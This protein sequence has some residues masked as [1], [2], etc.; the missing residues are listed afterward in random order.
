MARLA[1]R[2]QVMI[3]LPEEHGPRVPHVVDGVGLAATDDTLSAIADEHPFAD[4]RP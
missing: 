1:D 4:L 3:C 2:Q